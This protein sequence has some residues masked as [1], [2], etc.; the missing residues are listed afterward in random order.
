MP[1]E[2]M[3]TLSTTCC[4]TKQNDSSTHQEAKGFPHVE[5]VFILLHNIM[6]Q[7]YKL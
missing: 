3:V 1:D 4:T 2:Q 6:T 5:P 7:S